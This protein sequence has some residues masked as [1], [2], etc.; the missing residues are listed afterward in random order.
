MSSMIK[1]TITLAALAAAT[2]T[3]CA[4]AA[5]QS[6]TSEQR[7]WYANRL[8]VSGSNSVGSV[9]RA[10]PLGEAILQWNRLQQSDSLPFNDYAS[11]L[12]SHPDWPGEARMRRVAENQ[13]PATG[14]SAASLIA[15][16]DR[17]PPVTPSGALRYAEA[18]AATGRNEEARESAR[19]GWR[20]GAFNRNSAPADEAALL[21]RFGSALTA[22]DHDARFDELLWQG[23]TGAA[24]RVIS[25]TSASR[26]DAHSARLRLATGAGAEAGGSAMGDPGYVAARASWLRNNGR[27]AEARNLLANRTALQYRPSDAEE[28][29]EVLLTN[30]RSAAND[31]QWTLAYGIA[32]RVDDAFD[33]GT[34]VSEQALGVRDDYTSLVWLAGT[35]ALWEQNRPTEAIGMF[36]RYGRAARTPQTRSK[37]FY[38]AGRAAEAAGQRDAAN[39]FYE[40]AAAYYDYFYG[41]L[42]TERLGRSLSV[43]VVRRQPPST[44]AQQAF[45]GREIVQAIRML[46][47]LGAWDK[48]SAFLREL[49]QQVETDDEHQLAAMLASQL[50]RQDLAVMTHRSARVNGFDASD[51]GYPT[52]NMPAGTERYFSIVHAIARQESQFDPRAVSHAGARGLMQFMPATAQ[53][54]SRWIGRGYSPSAL[55]S[56]PQYSIQLGRAYYE[57]LYERWGNHV[58]AAASYN[59]GPGNVNRWIRANGDPRTPGVDIV[60]WIEEIPIYETKNYVQRVMENAVMYDLLNPNRAFIRNTTTPLTRYL[61]KSTPG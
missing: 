5:A 50:G 22:E 51:Y 24:G 30:A 56:D 23:D 35:T 9:P 31:R 58:L 6:L 8:G 44:E 34:D 38:W 28:W 33:P 39:R 27:S 36:E 49:A 3:A 59:A 19:R 18:L 15:F 57:N 45:Y 48:Q 41:Q 17:H 37:G 25:L 55:T 61:G 29:Y 43:P 52:V 20:M 7:A 46:G 60:R 42:A 47:E 40:E 11:F 54:V 4:P 14:T 32:S 13:I 1:H 12:V 10:N 2:L 26:R 53:E 16:F 21:G